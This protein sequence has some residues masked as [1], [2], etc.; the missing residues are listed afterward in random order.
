MVDFRYWGKMIGG[1]VFESVKKQAEHMSMNT[2]PTGNTPNRNP[3]FDYEKIIR[4]IVEE[5]IRCAAA[6]WYQYKQK[7]KGNGTEV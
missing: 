5:L 6:K 1:L 3:N 2:Y 7:N 4:T